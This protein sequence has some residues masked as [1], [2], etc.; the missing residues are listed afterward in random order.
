ML[1]MLFSLAA[2]LFGYWLHGFLDVD[3]CL[4]LG[5]RWIA[6]LDVCVTPSD[7]SL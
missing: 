3:D 5:G 4:N 7:F 1:L 2:F 6:E